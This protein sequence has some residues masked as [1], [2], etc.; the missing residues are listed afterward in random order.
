MKSAEFHAKYGDDA[1]Y[2]PDPKDERLEDWQ[3]EVYNGDT[4][5][6]FWDWVENRDEEEQA[7]EQ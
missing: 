1:D 5:L 3:T 7:D 2:W 4:L 6:G